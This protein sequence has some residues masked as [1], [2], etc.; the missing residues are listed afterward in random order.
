[1][2]TVDVLKGAKELVAKGWCQG[3]RAMDKDGQ[4][5]DPKD[6][7]AVR[8]CLLGSV[9]A[10]SPRMVEEIY[11]SVVLQEVA[12]G[13]AGRWGLHS[14]NYISYNDDESRTHEDVLEFLDK[15]IELAESKNE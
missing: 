11:A 8:W 2:K 14:L 10:V 1:M 6:P 4:R 3:T 9:A 13:M 12:R 5:V 7:N 15:A